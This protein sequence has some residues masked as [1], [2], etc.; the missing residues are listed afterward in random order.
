MN[1]GWELI[2][3]VGAALRGVI[4]SLKVRGYFGRYKAGAI[5][6]FRA[7]IEKR[8]YTSSSSR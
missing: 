1:E 2:Y 7:G 6:Y 5:V 3:S 8:I 4:E